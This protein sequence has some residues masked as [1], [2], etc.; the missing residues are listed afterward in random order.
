[1]SFFVPRPNK[2]PKIYGYTETS[3]E[4]DGLIKVGYTERKL[5]ERLT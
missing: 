3:P 4:F 5:Q 2:E 1:M